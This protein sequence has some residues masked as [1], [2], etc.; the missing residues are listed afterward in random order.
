MAII[1]M[2]CTASASGGTLNSN[3]KEVAEALLKQKI[4]E[5]GEKLDQLK[6]LQAQL[7]KQKK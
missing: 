6:R 2:E 7:E 5:L 1:P 3:Q 4:Q